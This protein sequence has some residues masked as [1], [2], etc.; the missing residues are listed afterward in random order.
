VVGHSRGPTG[1][2]LQNQ[3][4]GTEGSEKKV[5]EKNG[6]TVECGATSQIL[7]EK[8]GSRGVGEEEKGCTAV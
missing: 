3:P 6:R 8:G 7:E 2:G 1:E 4:Q 5:L